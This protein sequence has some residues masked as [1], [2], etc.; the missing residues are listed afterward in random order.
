MNDK[1]D[2]RN[3]LKASGQALAAVTAGAALSATNS[4]AAASPPAAGQPAKEGFKKAVH[5]NMVREG[6]TILDKLKLIKELGF[7]GV[8]MDSPNGY[9]ADEVVKAL[10]QTGI[11]VSDLIDSVHWRD[12]LSHPEAKVRQA[13]L[14]GL[15]AA[16]KDAKKYGCGSVLL[17]PAV[18]SKEVS[19]ADA[20]KRSQEEIRKAVPLA[21][22]LG[23]KI[24]IENVWNHFL[25]SPLEFA[26]YIDEFES[27]WIGAHFDVGNIVNYGWPE[28]WIRILGKRTVRLHIK[29]FSRSKRDKEGLWKGFDVELLEGDCNWPEVMKALREVGYQGWGTAEIP[30]GDAKRLKEIAARMDK[31]FSLP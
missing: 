11:E 28:Q 5:L 27:L 31:I 4:P 14:E 23:V 16:L 19:Y 7:D 24:A 30:G 13:G 3:F 26:R 29:E 20:Y 12:T 9:N 15:R 17:V 1:I 6:A 18:V 10:Q 22:E 25:L 2:R 21:A 8:E